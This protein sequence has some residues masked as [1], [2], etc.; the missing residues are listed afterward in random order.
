ME[1]LIVLDEEVMR[2]KLDDEQL[3]QLWIDGAMIM[4]KSESTY[5]CGGKWYPIPEMDI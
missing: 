4:N 2:A 5:Y 1:Y 3:Q